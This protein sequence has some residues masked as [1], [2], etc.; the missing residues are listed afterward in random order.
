MPAGR[1]WDYLNPQYAGMRSAAAGGRKTPQRYMAPARQPKQ[2]A[3]APPSSA[4]QR[5]GQ[6]RGAVAPFANFIPVAGPGIA[7]G[8]GAASTAIPAID[9]AAQT[10]SERDI[11]NAVIGTIGGAGRVAG[12]FAPNPM[13]GTIEQPAPME[14]AL[15]APDLMRGAMA[16]QPQPGT[17]GWLASHA[18]VPSGQVPRSWVSPNQMPRLRSRWFSR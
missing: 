14:A 16:P 9:L 1:P 4:S 11:G 17:P 3:P 10:G 12:A 2:E 7:A 13:A 6:I 8:L 18:G 5:A 15:Q